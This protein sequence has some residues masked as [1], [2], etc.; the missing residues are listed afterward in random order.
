MGR[1]AV[2]KLHLVYRESPDQDSLVFTSPARAIEIDRLR[3]A[4]ET[5]ETWGE[6]RRRIGPEAHADLY[7]DDFYDPDPDDD[8]EDSGEN[9]LESS[10]DALFNSDWTEASRR[11]K[12]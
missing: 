1:Q 10:G 9:A 6:F 3:R 4:I 11:R 2:C 7:G 8:S 5:S 12:G